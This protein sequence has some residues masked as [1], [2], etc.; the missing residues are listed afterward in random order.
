MIIFFITVF[1]RINN[2][3]P[4]TTRDIA[5]R[6]SRAS[7]LI[8]MKKT[9]TAT[10]KLKMITKNFNRNQKNKHHHIY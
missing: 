1:M 6:L 2:V 4:R 10:P 5:R 9:K 8:R 3:N 7:K